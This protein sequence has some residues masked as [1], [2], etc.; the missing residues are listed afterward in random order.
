[1]TTSDAKKVLKQI[2]TKPA[3]YIKFQK[4]NL[5]NK[6]KFGKATKKCR[7][8]GRTGAH[9]SKY[10]LVLCRQCFREIALNLGFKKYS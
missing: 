10:G 3:K 7:R 9:I 5:P 4:H 6:R 2:K 1:M 8:C